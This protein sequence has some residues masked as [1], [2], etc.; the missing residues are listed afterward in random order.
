LQEEFLALVPFMLSVPALGGSKGID[1]LLFLAPALLTAVQDSEEC[2]VWCHEAGVTARGL[3]LILSFRDGGV[4]SSQLCSLAE[5]LR[6]LLL[7]PDAPEGKGPHSPSAAVGRS[8][9]DLL[10]FAPHLAKSVASARKGSQVA[11]FVD[12]LFALGT[13]LCLLLAW[14]S[15]QTKDS[16]KNLK[17]DQES[18]RRFWTMCSELFSAENDDAEV[19]G[20]LLPLAIDL[21]DD[22]NSA[23]VHLI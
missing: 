10:A 3:P 19:L 4:S 18:L 15:Q 22:C 17:C 1:P 7:S 13:V 2:V 9:Q 23:G 20:D 16:V 14:F 11:D 5:L 8:M 21:L 12:L 6:T